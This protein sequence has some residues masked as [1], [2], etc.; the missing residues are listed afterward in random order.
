MEHTGFCIHLYSNT[1]FLFLF[2]FFV[3]PITLLQ[4]LADMEFRP[5]DHASE[6]QLKLDVIAVYNRRLDERE[7]RKRF[8]IE[9]NLLDYKKNL[10][11]KMIKVWSVAPVFCVPR[12]RRVLFFLLLCMLYY[13]KSFWWIVAYLCF[14]RGEKNATLYLAPVLL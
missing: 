2:L 14:K 11:K 13:Y 4:L 7:K 6:K 12:S 8:V 3:H 5:T 9:H 10:N 1:V